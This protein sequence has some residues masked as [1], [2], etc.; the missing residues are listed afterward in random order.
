M[1]GASS[2]IVA[3]EQVVSFW[4]PS[5][6]VEYLPEVVELTVDVTNNLNG[7]LELEEYRL[8]SKDVLRGQAQLRDVLLANFDVFSSLRLLGIYSDLLIFL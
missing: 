6:H 2:L 1:H 5:L 4:R 8:I 3:E 7:R